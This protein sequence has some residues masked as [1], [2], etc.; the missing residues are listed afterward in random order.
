MA[1]L[2]EPLDD[3]A[4]V[5][6]STGTQVVSA[7]ARTE[8]ERVGGRRPLPAPRRPIRASAPQPSGPPAL[9]ITAVIIVVAVRGL[10]S[11]ALT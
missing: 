8:A 3:A 9:L 5:R 6:R 7:R 2:F 10:P 4:P 11:P 1:V